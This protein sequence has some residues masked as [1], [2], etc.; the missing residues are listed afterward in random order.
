[1]T[2]TIT[3]EAKV[4]EHYIP[5]RGQG[6]YSLGQGSRLQSSLSTIVGLHLE[7]LLGRPLRR[8]DRVL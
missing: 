6:I 4:I 2:G 1:M 7:P 5:H 8:F 3:K